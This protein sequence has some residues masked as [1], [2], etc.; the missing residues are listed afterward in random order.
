MTI[1]KRLRYEVMRR[2]EFSCR[3]C[4]RSSREV[5][6]QV[7]HIIPRTLGG[8]D[9]LDNLVAAC[10]DCNAGK[11]STMPDPGTQQAITSGAKLWREAM[12]IAASEA[13]NEIDAS[14]DAL[15]AVS[16]RWFAWKFPDGTNVERPDHWQGSVRTWFNRGL[17]IEAMVESVDIAMSATHIAPENVWRYFCG[18]AWNKVNKLEQRAKE[19]LEE[20]GHGST[21]KEEGLRESVEDEDTA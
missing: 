17:P 19:L 10:T 1:S 15:V 12:A 4:G 9:E 6:L 8:H 13:E 14:N 20:A 16:Q 21:G 7:D 3:Y 2:D 18:V 11:G 5:K